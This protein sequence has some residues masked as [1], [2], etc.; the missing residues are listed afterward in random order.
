MKETVNKTI[1]I[2][3]SLSHPKTQNHDLLE[4]GPVLEPDRSYK[5]ALHTA[6][7][8]HNKQIAHIVL[9]CLDVSM[10]TVVFPFTSSKSPLSVTTDARY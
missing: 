1:V 9:C 6:T 8:T 10:D 2:G 7:H 4:L 3:S 5:K